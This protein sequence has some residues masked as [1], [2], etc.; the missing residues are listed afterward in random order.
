MAKKI[1]LIIDDNEIDRELYK[2][3]IGKSMP[4]Q[5]NFIEFENARGGID[6]IKKDKPFDLVLLDYR[7]PDF[8]G[9]ETLEMLTSFLMGR[10][11]PVVVLTGD[12][13]EDIAVQALK[14]GAQDYINKDNLTRQSLQRAVENAIERV[15]LESRIKEQTE[16]LKRS[17][18][19]MKSFA[20]VVAHDLRSPAAT[21]SSFSHLLLRDAKS[22]ENAQSHGFI[23]RIHAVSDRMILLIDGLLNFAKLSTTEIEMQSIELNE[24]LAEVLH[25]LNQLIDTNSAKIEFGELPTVY[26]DRIMV[27]QVILNLVSNAIKFHKPNLPPT[28]KLS[29]EVKGNF[30]TVQIADDGIGFEMSKVDMIFKP[31]ERLVGKSEFEGSGL[32]LSI[33]KKTIERMGGRIEVQSE[34]GEGTTFTLNLLH[35][36]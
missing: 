1:V 34:P 21:I 8:T 32:G 14:L 35:R 11:L 22:K 17:Y 28:I 13:N 12:G 33:A 10:A 4:G 36:E 31:L 6:Y 27:Y 16:E 24:V 2:R 23:Q 15:S 18:D 30:S 9:L 5:F 26:G 25:D 3:H 19:A 20:Y 29:G 7:L